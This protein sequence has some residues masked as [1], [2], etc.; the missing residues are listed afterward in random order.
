MSIFQGLAVPVT[1]L[2]SLSFAARPIR[3]TWYVSPIRGLPFKTHNWLTPIKIMMITSFAELPVR[4]PL[5]R[6]SRFAYSPKEATFSFTHSTIS[7]LFDS[8]DLYVNR[9]RVATF[10]QV[11]GSIQLTRL[12][13]VIAA[14]LP[15]TKPLRLLLGMLGIRL[16]KDK[17]FGHTIQLG[18]GVIYRITD[19]IENIPLELTG[20]TIGRYERV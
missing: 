2:P 13:P 11:E 16:F 6:L 12:Y 15:Q 1:S 7:S 3:P 8:V 20:I 18:S 19:S 17:K 14:G 10:T 5:G 4:Y 9:I